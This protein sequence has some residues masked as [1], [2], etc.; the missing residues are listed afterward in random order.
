M[1]IIFKSVG[2]SD[3]KKY[4]I[5]VI[6]NGAVTLLEVQNIY[7]NFGLDDNDLSHVKFIANSKTMEPNDKYLVNEEVNLHIFVFSTIKTVKEKLEEIFI[8]NNSLAVEEAESSEIVVQSINTFLKKNI[9]NA[10]ETFVLDDEKV[11]SINEKTIKLFESE[12]FKNLIR[13]YYSNQDVMKTFLSYIVHGDIVKITIPQSSD[14]SFESE[15]TVLK[16]LGIK[17]SDEEIKSALNR[18]NGHIN[19]TLRALLTKSQVKSN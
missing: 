9:D 15:I 13:I 5:K 19:L 16:S 7:K 4:E 6:M 3:P 2:T 12:D 14:K 18:F 1:P 10:E 8:K 11:K 17:N